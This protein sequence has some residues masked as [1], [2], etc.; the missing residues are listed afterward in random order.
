MF[1]EFLGE[2]EKRD[3][4][5]VDYVLRLFGDKIFEARR[6]YREY[7]RKRVDFGRRTEL[8]GGGLLRSSGGWGIL[9]AMSKAHIHLKGDERILGG[10]AFVEE[11]L[12]KGDTVMNK[13]ITI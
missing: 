9:K 11:V 13:C 7:V 4:Q 10:S 2:A 5:D 1:E 3:F 8:V 12:S 6:N